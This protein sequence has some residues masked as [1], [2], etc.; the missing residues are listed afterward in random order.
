[1]SDRPQYL[2]ELR[3]LDAMRKRLER[4]DMEAQDLVAESRH[5]RLVSRQ[6]RHRIHPQREKE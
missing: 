4:L 2:D 6:L 3:A 1:M 5:L